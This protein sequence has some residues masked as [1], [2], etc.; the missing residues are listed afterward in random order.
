[1]R[2]GTTFPQAWVGQL[3]SYTPS[4]HATLSTGA[5]PARQGV[6]G[7]EWRDPT[8]GQ[9][10]YTGW[11]ADVIAGRLELQLQQHGVDSIPQALKRQ[12]PNARVV[13][14]SSE[15]YYAADAMGGPAADYILYGLPRGSTITT[16]G[17]PHHVPPDT[18]LQTATLS[19]PWPLRLGQ[20][21]ELSMTMALESLRALDPRALLINLPGP[22]IYGH[23]VG[24]PAR[25]TA[26]GILVKGCDDQLGRLIAAYR[27]R[28][29]LDQTLLVVV[30]DHGMVRNTHQLDEE[31]L[32]Q[33]IRQEGEYLF[34]TG[35]NSAFIWVKDPTTAPKVAQ[36]LVDI[37]PHCPFAHY[38]T[39]ES[40]RYTYYPVTPTGTTLDP[41]LERAMQYL[42]S[43]FAGPLAPDVSLAFEE[44]TITRWH[45]NAHGEH[46]GATW[47]AQQ[48]PLIIAGPG[49]RT[50]FR[51]PFP[52]RL[53][54][55]APTVLALLGIQSGLMDGI[56]LADALL[57]PT[58][59]QERTQDLLAAPLLAYQR[60]IIARSEAD[61]ALQNPP[62]VRVP[63]PPPGHPQ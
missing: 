57:T 4:S 33:T 62:F 42:L 23:R 25:P 49:V 21:D 34:H 16:Q 44:N 63:K 37:M 35:G 30:G 36:H 58:Y 8:T 18:F 26:M 47:G 46:G 39:V 38:Q 32:K 11:Y 6:I 41:A 9:E 31:V 15:K 50:N 20:F 17:I 2:R 28:G 54:D 10:A 52:A 59:V 7:F 60:A 29:I 61:I 56:A 48:V 19:R 51:S 43:T 12:D 27:D 55:V 53:M 1:M 24:G 40:G 14:L 13:S 45:P 22:D 3:E 5:T